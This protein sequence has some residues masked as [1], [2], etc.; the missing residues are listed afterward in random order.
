MILLFNYFTPLLSDDFGYSAQVRMASSFADLIRQERNQYLTWS[1][2]SVV[3]LLLRVFLSLPRPAFKILNSA[4]F[5]LLSVMIYRNIEGRKHY[6]AFVMLLVQLGMWL[7]LV[8]FRQTILWETGACNYLWGTAII[9]SF[10]TW[11]RKLDRGSTLKLASAKGILTAV[12]ALLFGIVAGWCNE[13]TSGASLL[14]LLYLAVRGWKKEKRKPGPALIAGILGNAFGLYMMVT[15]PGNAERAAY[16][17]ENHSGFYG[18]ASRLQKIT[19]TVREYFFVMMVLFAAALIVSFLQ[20]RGTV[21]RA[22]WKT[23]FAEHENE[24]VFAALFVVTAYALILT[25]QT[26]PRAFFGAGVFLLIACIQAALRCLRNEEKDPDGT[27]LIQGI[28]YIGAA[29][30]S[31]HLFFVWMDDGANLARVYRDCTERMNF[32][33]QQKESGENTA[34]VAQLHPDFDNSFTVAYECELSEDP[35]YWT[36]VAMEEYF[37]MEAISAIPY[38]DWAE[39]YRDR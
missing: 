36:N 34:V 39:Q 21:K 9:L 2:R 11:M 18:M 27:Y 19:L 28:L 3:H 6:D 16:A 13:N 35:E 1:G 15:A 8:D 38:D 33:V 24:L 4:A 7:S 22:D 17:E 37:E 30:L 5:V 31:L 23:Y 20:K 26:Q 29:A 32:I 14:F 25:A 12:L 10:L